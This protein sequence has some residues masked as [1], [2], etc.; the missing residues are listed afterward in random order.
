VGAKQQKVE[1]ATKSTKSAPGG[2]IWTQANTKFQFGE[3]FL[4]EAE[5]E[6]VGLGCV[7]LHAWYMKEC[8]EHRTGGI[9]AVIK[10]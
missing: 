4:S 5:L 8:E 2:S 10:R 9:I 6:K 7:V 3:S 1:K